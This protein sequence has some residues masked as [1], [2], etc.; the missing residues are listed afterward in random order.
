MI[1][2]TRT[3][4]T[5]GEIRAALEQAM[6][7]NPRKQVFFADA[8]TGGYNLVAGPDSEKYDLHFNFL[9]YDGWQGIRRCYWKEVPGYAER[10]CEK[11]VKI[12]KGLKN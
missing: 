3:N 12:M 5:V 2:S 6:A 11:L 9:D 10:T 1:I 4:Q 7:I 8:E